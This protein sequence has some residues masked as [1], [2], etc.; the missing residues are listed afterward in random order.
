M[1]DKAFI[2]ELLEARKQTFK[3]DYEKGWNDCLDD[4]LMQLKKTGNPKKIIFQYYGEKTF[5][6]DQGS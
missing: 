6:E 1:N 5:S 4:M 2:S 3:M